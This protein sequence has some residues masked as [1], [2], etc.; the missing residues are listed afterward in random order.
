MATSAWQE[1]HTYIKGRTGSLLF[2]ETQVDCASTA[3][4]KAHPLVRTEVVADSKASSHLHIG[5]EPS[6]SSID[7]L[8]EACTTLHNPGL[9]SGSTADTYTNCYDVEIQVLDIPIDAL[10]IRRRYLCHCQQ[11]W[12]AWLGL[13][14]LLCPASNGTPHWLS[15]APASSVLGPAEEEICLKPPTQ[16]WWT[17][18]V[19]ACNTPCVY[20]WCGCVHSGGAAFMQRYLRSCH[21]T[22]S[23]TRRVQ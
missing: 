15:F 7:I 18:R 17:T 21:L 1:H 5:H 22:A 4:G 16:I 20:L 14:F 10:D 9:F 19:S 8:T 2:A 12:K 6:W 3:C 13:G 23:M 11:L